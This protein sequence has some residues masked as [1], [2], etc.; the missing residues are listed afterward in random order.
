[1]VD[2]YVHNFDSPHDTYVCYV[3]FSQLSDG[4][5][6]YGYDEFQALNFASDLDCILRTLDDICNLYFSDA[7][8]DIFYFD[9]ACNSG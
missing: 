7:D 8:E 1:M 2:R 3:E 4:H 5:L 9:D 6:F